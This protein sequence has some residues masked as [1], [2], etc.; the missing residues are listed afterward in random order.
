M[1]FNKELAR[2]QFVPHLLEDWSWADSFPIQ[3]ETLDV[4]LLQ[5]CRHIT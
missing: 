3:L 2:P 5:A 4:N 1:K